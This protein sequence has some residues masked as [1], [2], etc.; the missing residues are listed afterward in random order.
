MTP[1][2]GENIRSFGEPL[3]YALFGLFQ[4]KERVFESSEQMIQELKCTF[5]GC[6]VSWVCF[7]I[8]E[9]SMHLF[10]FVD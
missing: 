6:L 9:D 3:S 5:F 4:R 7:Y 8:G 2:W 1:L 10:E